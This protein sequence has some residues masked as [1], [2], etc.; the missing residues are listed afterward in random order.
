MSPLGRQVVFGGD[1]T[2][3]TAI[4]LVY[5][6]KTTNVPVQETVAIL[7]DFIINTSASAKKE[8]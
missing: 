2:I 7:A 5:A 6:A 4:A 1:S 3:A 8:K